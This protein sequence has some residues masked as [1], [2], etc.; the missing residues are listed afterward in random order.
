MDSTTE[1]SPYLP[2]HSSN[3]S[4]YSCTIRNA[5][6]PIRISSLSFCNDIEGTQ[7]I[8]FL[9]AFCSRSACSIVNAASRSTVVTVIIFTRVISSF[10]AAF[11]SI[12]N[13]M[14]LSIIAILLWLISILLY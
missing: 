4:P 9:I 3:S 2:S 11:I 1:L 14:F 12:A 5:A 8:R 7:A 13:A 6:W 10:F